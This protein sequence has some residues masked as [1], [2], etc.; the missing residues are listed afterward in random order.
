MVQRVAA[1]RENIL[2]RAHAANWVIDEPQLTDQ[3]IIRR[4][5]LKRCIY[6]VD[7]NP[8][9]VELA[10]VSLW[11][12]SFTVGAPLSFLD[13]H[14]RCGDSLIG[15]RVHDA[16]QELSRL[17]GFTS[18]SAIQA[19]ENATA[20]MQRIEEM[21]DADIAE[22]EQSAT[23]FREVEKTTADLRGL[24]NTLC[25]VNWLAAGMKKRQR[26]EFE[27]PLVG[28]IATQAEGAFSL[29]TN[30]PDSVDAADPIRQ[31]TYWPAFTEIWRAAKEVA[32]RENFLHW[33]SAFPG[34]WH[35]WQD[36]DPV[37]GFD[38]I[39]GNP[40]WD[41]IKLQEV[42][43]FATRS[44]E[45]ALSPTAA[46]R[47][48]GI[49]QLRD[50]GDPLAS[51]FDAAKLRADRLGQLIRASG[52]YPL[53]GGGDINLYSLFVERAMSMVKPD[54]IV[55]LLTPSGI[56][57]DKTAAR[58]FKSVSTSGRV[59]GLFDFENRRLGTELPP[60]F[61]DVDSRFKFCALIFGGEERSFAQTDCAFFLHDTAA[62][63][64]PNR[65]FP[66]APADFARVNPNTGTAPV[67]RTR[68][69]ADI[70]RR[71]YERHPVLVDRSGDEEDRVW[72]VR[73]MRM[74]DMTNDSHVFRT[75]A[76]LEADGFY[77]VQGNRWK[78]GETLYLPLY[79]G[80]MIWHLD[81]RANSVRVNP[82]STHNPY[83][84]EP[85]TEKQHADPSFLPQTQY[86]VPALEVETALPKS[87]G[88]TLGFRDIARPTDV[89]TMIA[90]VVPWAGYG[91]KLPLLIPQTDT[92]EFSAGVGA[93]L[94]SC[95]N[96]IA[97]DFVARQ[98]IHGTAL[99]WYIVEQLPVIAPADYDRA[100]GTTTARALVRDHVL[101]LT[102]T[103]HDMAPFAR[104]LGY[105][106]P[107]FIWNEEE[108]R[109]LR[110]RLDALYFH[111]YGLSRADAAYIL[112]T[113][114]IV[115]RHDKAAFGH[116]RTKAMVL[117]YYNALAAGDTDTD[118]A[119]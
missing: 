9:T 19:A 74:F 111:L 110:A 51:E 13:H 78:R 107:P 28:A 89:R 45:L 35:R 44:P 10:K 5:V 113:F 8:L 48:R 50:Q 65:C 76:Q 114:P 112:D 85:V 21:S 68:R 32:D 75:A 61:P 54:G 118:V 119:L 59:G 83:L 43:W 99:N 86:W 57:A 117:A 56:Y 23:L 96:S 103:A 4:M 22:V 42:E 66:L 11:L 53:L 7:K 71:I 27:A 16:T 81:H 93:L 3:A 82:E 79:Q 40:P 109:H 62:I 15:L 1:I 47:R 17:G 92:Q 106:G 6:G 116:Y 100:F 46:A 34:V 115:R 69:D 55:G 102:Y 73:Y 90:A 97:S 20:G 38:A 29:L 105:D 63:N 98:K 94:T 30:G 67:F 70:T 91:N 33:E 101:R 60:Y 104:D 26:A 64:D 39:I 24:L 77:P 37:G 52:H 84:S 49:K 58:F 12:H 14:L 31:H 18:A 72:P 95:L 80:R 41:R 108:R 88:W 36:D 25:G 87:K 2:A